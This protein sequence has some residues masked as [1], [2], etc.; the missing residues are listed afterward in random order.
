MKCDCLH[1]KEKVKARLSVFVDDDQKIERKP[2]L[3]NL[4]IFPPKL[5]EQDWIGCTSL[6]IAHHRK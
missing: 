1:S 6:L 4:L 2:K 3:V 5:S